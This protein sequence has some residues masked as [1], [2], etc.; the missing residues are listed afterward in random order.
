MRAEQTVSTHSFARKANRVV[1][2]VINSL[3]VGSLIVCIGALT[4]L[5]IT[6]VI[7]R[8]FFKSIYFAEEISEFLV[9]FTTFAGLSYGVRK[10]R[11]IR[12]GA[13]LDLMPA[14]LEKIFIIIIAAVSAAVMFLMADASYEYLMNSL[15]R[16]HETPA[17]R[18]PYWIFYV[19]MP[20]GFAMAGIQYIRTIV[21]NLTHKETWM[22]AEQQSE[23]ED[24]MP[25]E[26]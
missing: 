8:T 7:A 13:F 10:A 24:E 22:S 21:R 19:I 18:M 5:L 25:E 12:M 11:H 6:N 3:E 14:R 4:T 15:H 23:Y 2:H 16:S 9:I 1:G 20:A 26:V 17:L